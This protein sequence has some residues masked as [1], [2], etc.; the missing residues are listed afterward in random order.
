MRKT[1]RRNTELTNVSIK[2]DKK[3]AYDGKPVSRNRVQSRNKVPGKKGHISITSNA[4]GGF[5][6]A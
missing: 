1:K 3:I 2:I 6:Y 4:L 5:N